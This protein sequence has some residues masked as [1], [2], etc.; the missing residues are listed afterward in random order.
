MEISPLFAVD[1]E[2]LLE[3]GQV[4]EAIDLCLAGLEVYPGYPTGEAVL[5]RAYKMT[6]DTDKANEIL[7]DA[8]SK[9]PFNKALETLKKFDLEIQSVEKIERTSRFSKYSTKS[10][11]IKENFVE[12][13][14]F[15]DED[16]NL[17]TLQ[18]FKFDDEIDS[19]SE[20][21]VFEIESH[22]D[23]E[24][25]EFDTLKDFEDDLENVL[26]DN[27][28]EI[29]EEDLDIIDLGEEFENEGIEK[30]GFE[31]EE[32]VLID[33]E[34]IGL[35]SGLNKQGKILEIKPFK[36]EE[37]LNI[38]F[39]YNF[40]QFPERHQ[41]KVDDKIASLS[42]ESLANNLV[43]GN[44]SRNRIESV[45]SN[46]SDFN[47]GEIVTETMGEIYFEQGA[48][49]EAIKVFEKLKT[50]KPEKVKLYIKKIE[51]IEEEKEKDLNSK[52]NFNF[53]KDN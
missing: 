11:E 45:E 17:E 48:Y 34:D 42:L 40:K 7:E 36:K 18:D 2:E 49:N 5:A 16:D 15:D 43:E 46:I 23:D 22:T 26:D 44:A 14:K 3:K 28:I 27:E 38:K 50:Q 32:S 4:Q 19:Y 13:E 39:D 25:L 1:A 51:E 33:Y 52:R 35:I 37:I 21:D 31:S 9:N 47:V 41:I 12:L 24:E 29:L 53:K 8:I 30:E 10:I 20:S 6:G